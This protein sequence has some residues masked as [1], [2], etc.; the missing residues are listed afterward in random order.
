M[1][2]LANTLLELNKTISSCESFTGGLFAS[3]LTSISGIS[4][5]YKGSVV[6][7]SNEVKID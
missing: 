3:S 1:K 4:S 7:Y 6:S 2:R 5:V